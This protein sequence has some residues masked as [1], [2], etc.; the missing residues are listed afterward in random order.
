[1]TALRSSYHQFRSH[2]AGGYSISGGRALTGNFGAE[3]PPPDII[4]GVYCGGVEPI[5][6]GTSW[7]IWRPSGQSAS[8]ITEIAC[9]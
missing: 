8:L 4:V 2:R 6:R 7:L 5:N 1:M 3:P 9:S